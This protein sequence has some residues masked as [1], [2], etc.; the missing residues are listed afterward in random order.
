MHC[1]PK[2][3]EDEQVILLP[4]VFVSFFFFLGGGREMDGIIAIKMGHSLLFMIYDPQHVYN[5]LLY[6][7]R[8][9]KMTFDTL[10][11]DTDSTSDTE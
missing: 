11:T 1:Y 2:T 5:S 7:A 8:R 4:T 3:L 6:L 10:L 9:I